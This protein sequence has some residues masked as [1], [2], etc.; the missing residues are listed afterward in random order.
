M[1]VEV[2]RFI[3]WAGC[4]DMHSYFACLL[5]HLLPVPV[6]FVWMVVEVARFIAWRR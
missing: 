4:G 1:A 5:P 6:T 3:S 2:M